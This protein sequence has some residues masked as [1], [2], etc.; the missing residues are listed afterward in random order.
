M[1]KG[2]FFKKNIKKRKKE[3]KERSIKQRILEQKKKVEEKL[4]HV[5][6]VVTEIEKSPEPVVEKPEVKPE[7]VVSE[8]VVL[9]TNVIIDSWNGKYVDAMHQLLKKPNVTI[10]LTCLLYTSPSPRD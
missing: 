3:R 8:S 2:N 5:V 6:E 1:G 9:D 10:M 4:H 7:R